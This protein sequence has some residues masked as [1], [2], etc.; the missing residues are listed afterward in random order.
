MKD[1]GFVMCR[2]A[3]ERARFEKPIVYD[4]MT[5]YFDPWALETVR[6]IYGYDLYR[7]VM[8]EIRR[9]ENGKV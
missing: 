4:C 3:I 8:D 5:V 1:S 9:E 2:A 6:D 7:E